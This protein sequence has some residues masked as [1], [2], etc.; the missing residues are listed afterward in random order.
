MLS[1]ESRTNVLLR[2]TRH[3]CPCAAQGLF[4]FRSRFVSNFQNSQ[5]AKLQKIHLIKHY[6]A[7]SL[8]YIAPF[9][10][11]ADPGYSLPAY[12]L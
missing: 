5:K 8:K 9:V 2:D 11:S 4:K 1:L 6:K 7:V 12:L 10:P 3:Y